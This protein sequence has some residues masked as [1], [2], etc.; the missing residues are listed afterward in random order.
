MFRWWSRKFRLF[1]LLH[2]L[3]CWAPLKV[4]T[5]EVWCVPLLLVCIIVKGRAVDGQYGNRRKMSRWAK[6][7]K[8]N[9]SNQK[10][11]Y[12]IGKNEAR[13]WNRRFFVRRKTRTHLHFNAKSPQTANNGKH[14]SVWSVWIAVYSLNWCY[15]SHSHWTS[16]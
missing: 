15:F 9:K 10:S 3:W 1:F 16:S 5:R 4:M 8:S 2:D 7:E 11:Y 6:Y 13:V 12:K 14:V